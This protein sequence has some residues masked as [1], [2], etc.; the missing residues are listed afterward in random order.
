MLIMQKGDVFLDQPKI[1]IIIPVYNAEKYIKRC[2]DSLVNQTY[3]NWEAI[4]IDDASTDNSREMVKEYIAGDER[5]NFVTLDEN[6]GVSKVRNLALSMVREKYMAFLDSDDY[7][8]PNTLEVMIKKAEESDFDIVQCRYIYDY[9]GEKQVLPRG[10]FDE[11]TVLDKSNMKKVYFKMATGINMNHVCMKL[12]KTELTK[13]IEFDTDLKTAED[14]NFCVK[15]FSKVSKYCF[16]D[17]VMY[18]YCRNEDSLTGKGLSAKE[19]LKA[20]R[21]VSKT[22]IAELPAWGVD[23]LYWRILCSMRPYTIM[24][25]KII[26]T[27]KEKAF[28]KK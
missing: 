25:S 24:V 4:V 22:M 12:I 13:G 18:H 28:S 14:L 6:H 26:R 5:F 20:N 27:I 21:A 23:T 17:E 16:I 11:E 15:L 8:E 3:K 9:P 19:K 2:F 7:W 1:Q 10:A